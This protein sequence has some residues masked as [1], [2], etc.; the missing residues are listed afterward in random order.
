[1]RATWQ[2][3]WCAAGAGVRGTARRPEA[4][5]W[6]GEQGVEVVEADLADPDAL[7]RAAEGCGAVVHA[8]AWTGG[9]ELSGEAGYQ[10]NVDGTANALAAARR[11]A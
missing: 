10:V 7:A 1:M 6:L 5:G 2:S 8:A 11:A 9:P 4:A 3:G